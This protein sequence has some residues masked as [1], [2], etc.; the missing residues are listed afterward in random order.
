MAL[1]SALSGLIGAGVEHFESCQQA[2]RPGYSLPKAWIEFVVFLIVLFIVAL[3]G[4]LIWNEL[5]AGGPGVGKAMGKG[6]ITI[7]R[8]LPSVWHAIALYIAM[9]I[10]F[11]R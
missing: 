8:P 1:K 9:E 7:F 3:F 10:F 4:K 11:G 5:I 6:F 2:T